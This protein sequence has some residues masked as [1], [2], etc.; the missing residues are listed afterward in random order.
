MA[1]QFLFSASFLAISILR[2]HSKYESRLGDFKD[3]SQPN[4]L[5]FLLRRA[6]ELKVTDPRD[7]VYALLG[8]IQGASNIEDLRPDYQKSYP[9]LCYNLAG[10]F[11]KAGNFCFLDQCD[12]TWAGL[13]SWVPSIQFGGQQDIMHW[14]GQRHMLSSDLRLL[15]IR[16]IPHSTIIDRFKLARLD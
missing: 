10:Y 15:S 16:C 3:L 2:I 7:R 9:Q 12:G 13:P 6:A 11:A 14:E 1:E 8:L 4:Q 5:S